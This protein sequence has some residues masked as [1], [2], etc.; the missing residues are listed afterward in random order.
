[1]KTAHAVFFRLFIFCSFLSIRSGAQSPSWNL[2]FETWNLA[3]TTPALRFDTI[4]ENRV[5]LFPPNWHFNP[6]VIPEGKGLGRTTDATHGNYAVA[7]SGYYGYLIMRIIS[8]ADDAKPG[9]PIDFRP[10]QLVGDYKAILLGTNCDSLRTYVDVV[11][12]NFNGAL[13]RQDTIGR[14]HLTLLETGTEYQHFEV[15]IDYLDDFS[16]PDTVL[17]T[18]AEERFGFDSPPRCLECSHV[19][20]D[21]LKLTTISSVSHALTSSN[22]IS[23]F[24]NPAKERFTVKFKNEGSTFD[25]SIFSATGQL[26]HYYDDVMSPLSISTRSLGKGLCFIKIDNTETGEIHYEKICIK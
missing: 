8:G 11:L 18:L 4:V 5:G 7:L 25:I 6:D 12:T 16:I 20:F 15:D 1:M 14:G 26:L 22:K 23:I 10:D 24:P 3:D 17:I 21:D 19:Y 9:W 13:Q 2:D